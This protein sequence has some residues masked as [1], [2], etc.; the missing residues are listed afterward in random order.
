MYALDHH[1]DD[2]DAARCLPTFRA[3]MNASAASSALP[4]QFINRNPPPAQR[5]SHPVSPMKL[6]FLGV[7][8]REKAAHRSCVVPHWLVKIPI[9]AC[10]IVV[11]HPLDVTCD[12]K[13]GTVVD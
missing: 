12:F 1:D 10:L 2:V 3:E 9:R 7:E 13:Q 4:R 8:K 6:H 5:N 11:R